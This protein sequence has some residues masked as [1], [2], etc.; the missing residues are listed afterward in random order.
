MFHY[1]DTTVF[2][3]DAQMIVNT[4]NCVGV[5]GNGLALECR[6]RYREMFTDYVDRCRSGEVRIGEPY[7]YWYTAAFGILNFP[8]KDHWKFPSRVDWIRRGLAG[9]LALLPKYPVSSVRVR[10]GTAGLAR[11]SAHRRRDAGRLAV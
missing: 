9:F 2:N 4:V 10:P 11:D 6:L 1:T 7:F 5:M 3:V 8:C